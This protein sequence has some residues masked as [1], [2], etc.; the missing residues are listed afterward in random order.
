MNSAPF[1]RLCIATLSFFILTTVKQLYK[2]VD[3]A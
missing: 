1:R 2:V 3:M